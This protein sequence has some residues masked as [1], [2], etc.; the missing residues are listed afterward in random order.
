M[1]KKIWEIFFVFVRYLTTHLEILHKRGAASKRIDSKK[2][3]SLKINK[4]EINNFKELLKE[5]VVSLRN[6]R[7][8][9]ISYPN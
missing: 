4:I 1:K 3:P 6:S 9:K 7:S 2:K 8:L 5:R